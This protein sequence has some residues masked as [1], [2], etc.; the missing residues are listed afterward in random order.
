MRIINYVTVLLLVCSVA[1]KKEAASTDVQPATE[2]STAIDTGNFHRL[3][4]VVN[5]AA[6][7][8]NADDNPTGSKATVYF[9]LENNKS[10]SEQYA[11]TS[12]W[13][14]AFGSLYNSYISGNNG[15]TVGNYGYGNRAAGGIAI[16]EKQFE[17]VTTLPANIVFKTA[18]DVFGGDAGGDFGNGAGWYLYDFG[19]T[20]VRDG[21]Y[22]NQHVAYALGSP[23]TLATGAVIP[24]RTL[25]VKTCNGHYAKIKM[26]SVYKNALKQEEWFRTTPHMFFTFEYVMIP[27]GE[28]IF[29]VR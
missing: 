3:I 21:A 2:D 5:F 12:Q 4:R 8:A 1:C 16:V 14:M 17:E 23:L 25:I 7:T 19:G 13:D 6:D 18:K 26:I 28:S 24:A 10:V 20:L 11:K 9:S 27:K 15:T 29:T 22:D